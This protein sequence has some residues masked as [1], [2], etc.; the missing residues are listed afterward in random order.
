MIQVHLC[1]TSDGMKILSRT[2]NFYKLISEKDIGPC[3]EATHAPWSDSQ[4][5]KVVM[6]TPTV[7]TA[8]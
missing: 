2:N 5:Y 8:P 7:A 1:N 4:K 6:T 3:Q